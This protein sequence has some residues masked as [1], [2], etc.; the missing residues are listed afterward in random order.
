[1]RQS[2]AIRVLIAALIAFAVFI[3]WSLHVRR[4][5][6]QRHVCMNSLLAIEGAKE[7][8]AIEHDGSA[9]ADF[10]RLVPDYL[11]SVPECPSGGSYTLGNMQT[12]VVCSVVQHVVAWE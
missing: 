4:S 2:T 9:P 5:T 10:S 6:N 11:P 8:F 7:Q 3:V 12:G 1:M